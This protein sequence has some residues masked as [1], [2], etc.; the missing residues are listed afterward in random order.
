ML[1][2]LALFCVP[3]ETGRGK[4]SGTGW[5]GG[6]GREVEHSATATFMTK[7][8]GV[9]CA[10]LM[11][12]F[13]VWVFVCLFVCFVLVWFGLGFLGFFCSSFSLM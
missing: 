11:L 8:L 3:T 12:L 7:A 6:E 1:G 10:A 9:F 2:N 13:F 4:G 5:G